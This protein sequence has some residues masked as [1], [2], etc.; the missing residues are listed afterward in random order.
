M[1]NIDPVSRWRVIAEDLENQIR[2]GKLIPGD[3]LPSE[4]EACLQFHVARGTIK[5]AYRYLV[6]RGLAVVSVG[7][8]TIVSGGSKRLPARIAL[9]ADLDALRRLFLRMDLSPWERQQTIEQEI[10]KRVPFAQRPRVVFLECN[11]ELLHQ[12]SLQIQKLCG[13]ETRPFLL[14]QLAEHAERIAA[15]TDIIA[16]PYG[17]LNEVKAVLP[18]FP[19][20][21]Q[22][23][24]EISADTLNWF[25]KIPKIS[26][27]VLVY[28]SHRFLSLQNRYLDDLRLYQQRRFCQA[29]TDL[30]ALLQ[31]LDGVGA[32]ILPPCFRSPMVDQL[33]L[34][35]QK[36]HILC[37]PFNFMLDQGSLLKL[38]LEA[39]RLW[40]SRHG[41]PEPGDRREK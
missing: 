29:D 27:V 10:W 3:R 26:D 2:T 30:P 6:D 18:R 1:A 40:L 9:S 16:V 24:M 7:N 13:L 19:H 28:Q 14:S 31:Q 12:A 4:R 37:I 32:V 11:P 23:A 15:D 36:Q 5:E 39:R 25:A 17:H 33:E 35:C 20:I 34:C 8:G 21:T 38:E 41:T 22:I